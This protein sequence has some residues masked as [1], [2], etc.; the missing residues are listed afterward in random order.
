MTSR[1]IREQL[2][3]HTTVVDRYHIPEYCIVHETFVSIYHQ[4]YT[5]NI[6]MINWQMSPKYIHNMSSPNHL[7]IDYNMALD[8]PIHPTNLA[9]VGRQC[10][11]SQECRSLTWRLRSNWY[12]AKHGQH[13]AN[14]PVWVTKDVRMT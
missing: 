11:S 8:H 2:E 14:A 12:H 6:E 10:P 3:Q 7:H 5:N 4:E 9:K 1:M 13:V